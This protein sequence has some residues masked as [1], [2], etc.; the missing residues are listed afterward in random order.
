M[1]ASKSTWV[2]VNAGIR[3][4]RGGGAGRL[5]RP[6]GA[7]RAAAAFTLV[8]L[9]VV[10]GIIALLIGVLLPVLGVARQS[11]SSLKCLSNLHQIGLAI[12]LYANT[13]NNLIVPYDI[14][15]PDGS[16]CDNW[17]C[18]LVASKYMP[19]M[20]TANATDPVVSNS[21]LACPDS[22]PIIERGEFSTTS[23]VAC[24]GMSLVN[25]WAVGTGP[26]TFG[27]LKGAQFWRTESS[28]TPMTSPAQPWSWCDTSYG[29][30]GSS[31]AVY[32]TGQLIFPGVSWHIPGTPVTATQNNSLAKLSMAKRPQELVIV[33]DGIYSGLQ[34]NYARINARHKKNRSTNVLFL[35]GH[36]ASFNFSGKS[37]GDSNAF[38]HNS[39]DYTNPTAAGS[40]FQTHSNVPKFRF[41]Q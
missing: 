14:T 8:E 30:N 34:N 15:Q 26:T 3:D 37:S 4:G 9:L 6:G 18:I 39:A 25:G 20:N 38:T 10:I 40:F 11:A 35:D 5:A 36:A 27:D 7:G 17:A 28:L 41:D 23:P 19:N 2:E 33:F 21:P 31:T 1:V 22:I 32:G 13:N 24:N 29:F 12:N 16:S